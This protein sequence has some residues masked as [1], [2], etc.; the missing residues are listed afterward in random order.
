M[1][2]S[3]YCELTN[4]GYTPSVA[5]EATRNSIDVPL[6]QLPS[7]YGKRLCRCVFYRVSEARATRISPYWAHMQN[8]WNG[9]L[10]KGG[11]VFWGMDCQTNQ[12]Q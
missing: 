12:Q 4:T 3:K 1:S 5:N 10:G 9:E 11:M 2:S 7:K 8:S 6:N